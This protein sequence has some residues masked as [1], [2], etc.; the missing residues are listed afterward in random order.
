M[1]LRNRI[2]RLEQ[3]RNGPEGLTG[4]LYFHDE[5]IIVD[6]QFYAAIEDIPPE[7]REAHGDILVGKIESANGLTADVIAGGGASCNTIN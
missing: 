7:V 2:E 5:A 4:V 1:N 3:K 6:G